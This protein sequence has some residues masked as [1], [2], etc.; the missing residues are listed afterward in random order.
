MSLGG[1]ADDLGHEGLEQLERVVLGR[2]FKG[3]EESDERGGPTR[4]RQARQDGRLHP[5]SEAG[6]AKKEH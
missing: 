1:V 3:V 4:L 2:R 6:Q 5:L